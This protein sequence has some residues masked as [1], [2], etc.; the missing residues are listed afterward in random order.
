RIDG[1]RVIIEVADDGPGIPFELRDRVFEPYFTTK[2]HGAERGTGLGLATVSGIV[3]SHRGMIE[4]ADGLA[5]R[6]TT[7]RVR[8][9]IAAGVA[10]ARRPPRPPRATPVPA[11]ARSGIVLVVDDD[12]VVR[13][14]IAT[15]LA[16]LGYA[17][18]EAADGAHAVE[19]YRSHG[20]A[21]R[22]VLLDMV[23]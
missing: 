21:I 1:D 8:L 22:A 2:P 11:A 10:G 9:P 19:I 15:T 14:A 18:I 7:M 16:T 6:G 5:G 17:T 4:I 23:M 20:S 3:D 13:R 12:P